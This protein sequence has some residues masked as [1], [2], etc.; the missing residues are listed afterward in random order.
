[1]K[2]ELTHTMA[3]MLVPEEILQ[4]FE[5]VCIEEKTEEFILRLE[6]KAGRI[7]KAM[8]QKK[9]AVLDGFCN[10]L[11]LQTFSG[12]GQAGLS[13]VVSQVLEGEH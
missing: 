10:A 11:E 8:H 12:E 13:A 4:H 1:M 2:Q 7:P 6:E 9:K 3:S 5:L